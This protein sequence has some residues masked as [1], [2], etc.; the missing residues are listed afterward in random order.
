[1]YATR[2]VGLGLWGRCI[3][4]VREN[5]VSYARQ[6]M[7]YHMHVKTAY[8]M[9][10]KQVCIIYTPKSIFSYQYHEFSFLFGILFIR[11]L[12]RPG[13]PSRPL[14]WGKGGGDSKTHFA[15][16]VLFYYFHNY[17]KYKTM[18]FIVGGDNPQLE[19]NSNLTHHMYGFSDVVNLL[20]CS[21]GT[22]LHLKCG[23]LGTELRETRVTVK[24][25]E[26]WSLVKA[27]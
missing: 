6:Q 20:G 13:S 3:S 5:C 8:Y 23:E 12:M 17:L 27:S 21:P 1:M 22:A 25:K 7:S 16:F 18:L 19:M 26:A 9:H 15:P 11:I 10:S 14:L 4:Y 2:W 24:E